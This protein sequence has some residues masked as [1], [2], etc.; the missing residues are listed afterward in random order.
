MIVIDV[1]ESFRRRD[2]WR[3]VS[4]PGIVAQVNR[5]VD[6][7]RAAGDLV[8]WVLHAEPGSGT[9]FDPPAGFVRMMDGLDPREGEPV[10][11]KTS[12]NAFTTT[13]LQQ[14]LTAEGIR[15]LVVCGIQ[16]EQCCETTT[17]L[18]ADLGF[19]VTFVVDATAT[20]PIPHRDAPQGRTVEE[21]VADPRT[22][23]V[24]EIVARTEYALA[25]RFA[26]IASVDDLVG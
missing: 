23:G 20:F 7:A 8:V 19:D 6:R 1:Q 5:L 22:L 26:A 15:D 16:T 12:R 18:A 2:T 10:I 24:R 17:R 25:G 4:N 11:T 13:N 3:A 14:L 21:I 9:V